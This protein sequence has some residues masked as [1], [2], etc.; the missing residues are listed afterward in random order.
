MSLL[1]PAMFAPY[2]SVITERTVAECRGRGEAVDKDTG[3]RATRDAFGALSQFQRFLAE[4]VQLA[5][6]PDVTAGAYRPNTTKQRDLHITFAEVQILVAE[7][8]MSGKR[9]AAV[10]SAIMH[11]T[12]LDTTDV[13]TMDATSHQA[14]ARPAFRR[15]PVTSLHGATTESAMPP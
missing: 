10:Y 6:V 9:E 5:D 8:L 2:L 3:V 14:L 13:V 1:K 11:S 15:R 12:A 4:H 7:L